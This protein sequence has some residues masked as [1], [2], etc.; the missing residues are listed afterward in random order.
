MTKHK[1]YLSVSD[2]CKRNGIRTYK[3][4]Q[5]LGRHPELSR[6][7]KTNSAGKRVLDEEAM[8]AMKAILRKE[9][10]EGGQKSKPTS[11]AIEI[12]TLAAQNEE[13]RKEVAKLKRENVKLKKFLRGKNPKPENPKRI[14]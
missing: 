11:A 10:V 13:L 1:K 4:Y 8:L 2:F 5:I 7:L 14:S 9:K 6:K 3:F 12:N